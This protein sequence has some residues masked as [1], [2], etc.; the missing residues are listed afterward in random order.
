ME[1][2]LGECALTCFLSLKTHFNLTLSNMDTS[3]HLGWQT[4]GALYEKA[5]GNCDLL[6]RPKCLLNL[7]KD[8]GLHC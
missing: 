1:P 4:D 6:K 3:Y 5:S 2:G 8:R 7:N